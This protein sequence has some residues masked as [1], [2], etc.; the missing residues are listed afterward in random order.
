MDFEENQPKRQVGGIFAM[1]NATGTLL[2]G[3]AITAIGTILLLDHLGLVDAY[4][5]FRL[6]PLIFVVAG[7]LK[8]MVEGASPGARIFGGF[9]I[10]FGAILEFHEFGYVRFGFHQL[11]PLFLIIAGLLLAW[12]ANEVR[13]GRAGFRGPLDGMIGSLRR[14]SGPLKSVSIFGA[15]ERRI[16]GMLV[17]G[18]EIVAIFGG[19]KIDLSRAQMQGDHAAIDVTAIFG[20]GEIIIPEWWK[21]SLEGAAV[22]GAWEDKSRHHP[23]PDMPAKTLSIRGAAVFGGIE[24]KSY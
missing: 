5:L 20:G 17:E 21:V 6:W 12:H 22:F 13:E 9:L 2:S 16:E 14:Q 4:V 15:I 1:G 7:I 3:I 10:F 19:F 8:L 23:R 18:G 11:W 24:I